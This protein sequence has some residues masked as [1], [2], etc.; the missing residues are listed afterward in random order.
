MSL[1]ALTKY[2]RKYVKKY[3]V[4]FGNTPNIS[5]GEFYIGV[6]D[7]GEIIGIPTSPKMIKHSYNAIKKIIFN[8]VNEVISKHSSEMIKSIMNELKI[9]IIPLN[10]DP[11]FVCDN[12]ELILKNFKSM[13]ENF[14]DADNDYRQNKQYWLDNLLIYKQPI[15]TFI[16]IPEIR[17]QV[18]DLIKQ[19]DNVVPSVIDRLNDETPILYEYG[20][21]PK[22]KFDPYDVTYWIVKHRDEMCNKLQTMKPVHHGLT[23][24]AK[25][26]LSLLRELRPLVNSIV[27]V[28]PMILVKITYP[29]MNMIEKWERMSYNDGATVRYSYRTVDSRNDPCCVD[30]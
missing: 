18:I 29:S 6:A 19:S 11:D 20:E 9:E 22:R 17:Q 8:E 28:T 7:D 13:Y 24:P 5:H 23:R 1:N 14:I 15:N 12:H 30:F 3:L 21:I 16:N 27:Q 25:P 10:Y 26:Y 4:S 2:L